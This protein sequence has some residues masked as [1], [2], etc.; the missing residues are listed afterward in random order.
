MLF[1]ALLEDVYKRQV[2]VC[3]FSHEQ[4][5]PAYIC[6][7]EQNK[8][9]EY[10]PAVNKLQGQ[11]TSGPCSVSQK[12]AEAAYTG[13]Q[14]PV[15][16]MRQAFQRRRDP[17]SYTHLDVYKRQISKLS[18]STSGRMCTKELCGFHKT[19]VSKDS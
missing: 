6:Q 7:T 2:E 14:A 3:P 12:A 16:E 13:T 1:I 5:H 15:E 11:Y 10:F 8:N 9:Q 18:I 19:K 4:L 17:V